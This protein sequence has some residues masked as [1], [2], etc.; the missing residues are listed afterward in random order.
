MEDLTAFQRDLLY[1]IT[2]ADHPSGQDIKDKIERYYSNE[3]LYC[4]LVRFTV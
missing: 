1:V 2:D 4:V 3:I